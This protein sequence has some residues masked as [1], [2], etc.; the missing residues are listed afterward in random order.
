[1]KINCCVTIFCC[2][3]V[4]PFRRVDGITCHYEDSCFRFSCSVSKNTVSAELSLRVVVHQIISCEIFGGV[5]G[6]MVAWR[7]KQISDCVSRH[8]IQR[9]S[10]RSDMWLNRGFK[11]HW[12]SLDR[13]VALINQVFRLAVT[14]T[15]GT[16][17]SGLWLLELQPA[18]TTSL[19]QLR[20]L[21]GSICN[22]QRSQKSYP[23]FAMNALNSRIL[24]PSPSCNWFLY[25][26]VSKNFSLNPNFH[27]T[28][29]FGISEASLS[30]TR[31]YLDNFPLNGCCTKCSTE[32]LLQE[33]LLHPTFPL[34][35]IV[36]SLTPKSRHNRYILHRFC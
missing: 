19:Y 31:K 30:P 34:T 14:L 2:L 9:I 26:T 24:S 1:M 3:P 13:N 20:Q 12:R 11:R 22:Q 17:G 8:L 33:S 7:K 25:C 36:A 18:C 6:F 35:R 15:A 21:Q 10:E 28:S 4:R 29:S 32:C 16:N 23:D 27:P 5:K